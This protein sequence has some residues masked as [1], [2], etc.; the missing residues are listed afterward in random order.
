MSFELYIKNIKNLARHLGFKGP[1]ELDDQLGATF[2]ARP[3]NPLWINVSYNLETDQVQIDTLV[4]TE[5]PSSKLGVQTIMNELVGDLFRQKHAPSRLVAFPKEQAIKLIL[6]IDLKE[7]HEVTV[8]HAM[9]SFIRSAQNWKEKFKK[10]TYSKTPSAQAIPK[11][12][13]S[14]EKLSF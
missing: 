6:K 12:I 10:A 3:R 14:F 5:M 4:S 11:E 2:L 8:A 1:I 13:V 7:A 9:T